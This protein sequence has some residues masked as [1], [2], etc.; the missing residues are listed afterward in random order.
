[1]ESKEPHCYFDISMIIINLSVKV[2]IKITI[3]RTK[4]EL[5]FASFR[6]NR[7]EQKDEKECVGNLMERSLLIYCS[8]M[9]W[10]GTLDNRRIIM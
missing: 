10:R 5:S 1:M 3:R 7:E 8:I 4:D 9:K 6:I 2:A